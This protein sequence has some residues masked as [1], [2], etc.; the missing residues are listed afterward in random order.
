MLSLVQMLR[1]Q[2]SSGS[3]CIW[4][5]LL[6]KSRRLL[7]T[8]LFKT[9]CQ[10]YLILSTISGWTLDKLKNKICS[11]RNGSSGRP[12]GM[13]KLLPDL[14]KFKSTIKHKLFS[15]NKSCSRSNRDPHQ[16]KKV[17]SWKVKGG[18]S[19]EALFQLQLL[20]H[21]K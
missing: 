20:L 1:N 11:R 7:L 2:L 17:S 8:Y 14:R 6:S 12:V 9:S 19:K 10:K 5:Q 16:L 4:D 15:G 21:L 18:V 3:K 13:K